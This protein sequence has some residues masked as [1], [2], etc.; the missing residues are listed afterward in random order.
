MTISSDE[1]FD[2]ILKS[3][4]TF[5]GR[6]R[7]ASA[8]LWELTHSHKS[9]RIV[10]LRKNIP[11]NLMITC[12]DPLRIRGPVRWD[13]A[14]IVISRAPVPDDEQDGFLVVDVSADVEILC[15]SLEIKENVKLY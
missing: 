13:H 12:V 11:G 6:W 8:E 15:G 14:D 3:S 9:L 7:D 4:V 5:L 1:Y 10:L 2:K